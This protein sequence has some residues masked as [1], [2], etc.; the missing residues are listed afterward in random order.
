MTENDE[1]KQILYSSSQWKAFGIS[2]ATTTQCY[3]LQKQIQQ[4][5]RTIPPNRDFQIVQIH[6][7]QEENPKP[8]H[9][10][11]LVWGSSWGI[12][13]LLMIKITMIY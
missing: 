7:F 6:R 12:Q 5:N 8:R 13:V 3:S 2:F 1:V 10:F 9:H 4:E 11:F